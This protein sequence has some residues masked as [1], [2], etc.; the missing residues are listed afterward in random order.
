MANSVGPFGTEHLQDVATKMLA[1]G[2]IN[3]RLGSQQLFLCQSSVS[4]APRAQSCF[5]LR[6]KSPMAGEM[7]DVADLTGDPSRK[8]C[9]ECPF[10]STSRWC[11]SWCAAA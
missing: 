1:L 5:F 7:L 9:F 4:R 11:A 6:D 8:I 3:S 10:R 2:V